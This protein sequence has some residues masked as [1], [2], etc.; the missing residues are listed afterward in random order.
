MYNRYSGAC[1]AA[2]V[3]SVFAGRAAGAAIGVDSSQLLT[4]TGHVIQFRSPPSFDSA[5]TTYASAAFPNDA[6]N[7]VTTDGNSLAVL[8]NQTATNT[9]IG[10]P[11]NLY[12]VNEGW[13]SR[14]FSVVFHVD[15]PT[16]FQFSLKHTQLSAYQPDVKLIP[17]AGGGD[18]LTHLGVFGVQP[19]SGGL[20]PGTYTFSGSAGFEGVS[21]L[22]GPGP[23]QSASFPS[24]L[25]D[26]SLVVS[27]PEPGVVGI[28]GVVTSF[29]A[30]G[31]RRRG[32]R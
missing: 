20:A 4:G 22:A 11:S 28:A 26:V 30:L 18:L 31:R 14:K 13:S 16:M 24:R 17:S 3:L 9:V 29:L 6:S 2:L 8:V 25:E 15:V 5:P 21:G 23:G 1:A 12:V 7:Y 10:Q 27:V 32:Q 19:T